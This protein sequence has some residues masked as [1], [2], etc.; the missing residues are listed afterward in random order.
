MTSG[1]FLDGQVWTLE[2]RF[3]ITPILAWRWMI[4]NVVHLKG[5][6]EPDCWEFVDYSPDSCPEYVIIL[7]DKCNTHPVEKDTTLQEMID[8]KIFRAELHMHRMNNYVDADTCEGPRTQRVTQAIAWFGICANCNTG[9][10]CQSNDWKTESFRS[11][12]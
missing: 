11:Y 2:P 10:F 4:E 7:C 6:P 12:V 1:F 5:L 8:R 9:L 3:S